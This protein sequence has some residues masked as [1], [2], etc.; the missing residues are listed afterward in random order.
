[1]FYFLH[2][3]FNEGNAFPHWHQQKL[4]SGSKPLCQSLY[5]T[6]PPEDIEIHQ[7]TSCK[8]NIWD[9]LSYCFSLVD[10]CFSL[11]L[12]INDL[13]MYSSSVFSPKASCC[14]HRPPFP[15]VAFSCTMTELGV[16][17]SISLT[18]F[19]AATFTSL[20]FSGRQT[21][22]LLFTVGHLTIINNTFLPFPQSPALI[23]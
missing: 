3:S 13:Y 2:S 19:L 12:I 14:S 11:S 22:K 15:V 17:S 5:H 1:M 23:V 4:S 10:F 20:N 18:F 16:L 6:L 7:K 8:S 21:G 9:R